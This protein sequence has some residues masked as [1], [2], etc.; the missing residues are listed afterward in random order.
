MSLI[1]NPTNIDELRKREKHRFEEP[2]V[3]LVN[4]SKKFV[5]NL[6]QALEP[7]ERQ[8]IIG[9][10]MRMEV[11]KGEFDI[12]D[13]ELNHAKNWF[14]TPV[15]TNINGW[16]AN[17]HE[18]KFTLEY[19]VFTKRRRQVDENFNEY[20]M[21][22]NTIQT[23]GLPSEGL[24]KLD[25]GDGIL[26]NKPKLK[27]STKDAAQAQTKKTNLFIWMTKDFPIKFQSIMGAFR[28]FKLGNS[29]L[30]KLE[31]FLKNE[32]INT[33]IKSEGFP[34]K[35]QIP[36]TYSI[37]ANIAFANYRP[38]S[39]DQRNINDSATLFHIPEDFSIIDRK[40]AQKTLIRSKKR[41]LLSQ[42]VMQPRKTSKSH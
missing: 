25:V 31:V 33:L 26:K 40:V 29:F 7:D 11:I 1:L 15:S 21:R 38:L 9:D 39:E 28:F 10:L 22:M 20:L 32:S 27:I 24:Y 5:T 8:L 2:C 6:F 41:I 13:C 17:K 42:M 35:M 14:G 19:K 4:R 30:Q 16:E 3:L 12:Q 37:R 34:V 36:L 23:P 18:L